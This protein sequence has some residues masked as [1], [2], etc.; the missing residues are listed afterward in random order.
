MFKFSRLPIG[1]LALTV[2]APVFA[3][4]ATTPT[5]P[6][7]PAGATA[8]SMPSMPAAPKAMDSALHGTAAV[9]KTGLVD[10]NTATAADLRGLPGVSDADSS[11]IIQGRP[12]ADKNQLV[13]RHV[14]SEATY[15][16]IKDHVV[17]KQPKS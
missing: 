17:A 7:P 8:P 11:K 12:Y 6:T 15:D 9:P 16:K 1:L 2:A 14:V 4:P 5:S 3:Q 13:S 10:I